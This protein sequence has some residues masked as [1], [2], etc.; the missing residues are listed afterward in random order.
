MILSVINDKNNNDI[1]NNILTSYMIYK[2]VV[3]YT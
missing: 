2:Q 1:V 3:S